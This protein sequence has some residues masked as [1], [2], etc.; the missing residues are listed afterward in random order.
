MST[1]SSAVGLQ[2]NLHYDTKHV[3][4]IKDMAIF[5]HIFNI[6]Q[7]EEK[8]LYVSNEIQTGLQ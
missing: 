5:T 2:V 8:K 4:H 1:W 7:K 6:F 3:L